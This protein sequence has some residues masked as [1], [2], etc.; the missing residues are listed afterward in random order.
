MKKLLLLAAITLA[1]ASISSSFACG[2]YSEVDL[3]TAEFNRQFA[4]DNE[5]QNDESSS[6]TASGK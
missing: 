3:E 4:L 2:E 6:S 5:A 1:F